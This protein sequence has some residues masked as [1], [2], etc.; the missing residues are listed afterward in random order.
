M[1]EEV[2]LTKFD[3]TKNM[4]LVFVKSVTI[5]ISDLFMEFDFF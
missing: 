3:K 4:Q 5:K 2:N 1:I